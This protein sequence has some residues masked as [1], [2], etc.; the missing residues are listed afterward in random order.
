VAIGGKSKKILSKNFP[1]KEEKIYCIS[2]YSMRRA[3]ELKNID[4]NLRM[5]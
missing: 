5:K 1:E 4:E 3:R 2:H